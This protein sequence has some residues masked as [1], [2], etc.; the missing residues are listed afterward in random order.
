MSCPHVSGIA[1]LL[2][3]KHPD[4][5][6]AAIKSALMTTAYIHDNNQNPLTDASTARPSSPY[7]HGAGH[8]NPVKALD[9]GLIY[10]ID[11]QDYFDFL[12][13]Q[14]LESSQLVVFEKFSNRTCRHSIRNPGDLNYPAISAVFP[15]TANVTSVI[16]RRT[17]TNVGPPNSSYHVVISPFKGA[18][19]K[20]EP[21]RLNFNSRLKKLSYKITIT[22][23]SRQTAPE[24]GSLIWK[25]GLHRVRS[26]IMITWL[27]PV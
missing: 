13:T 2:K 25:D 4:W 7:D 18:V 12:C 16:L 15:E 26:P 20:V 3:S 23:K 21:A 9:P 11:A 6:P 8:V 24:F 17:V 5:S 1:A 10:D 27:P 14:G 19:V 22:T